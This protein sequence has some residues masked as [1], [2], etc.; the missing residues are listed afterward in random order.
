MAK[1]APDDV[2]AAADTVRLV[3]PRDGI[4]PVIDR[5]T[6]LR[7]AVDRYARSS[8]P[9][10]F[11]AE[12]ASGYRYSQRAYLIQLRRPDAGT[13][14]ID[15]TAVPDLTVVR[16]AFA[17]DEWVLHAAN[18]DLP[19]M[20]ELSLLPPRLFD[21]ELA[22]R[23]LG[24]PRVA[25]GTL[26]ETLLGYSLEKGHAAADWSTRPLP[27]DWLAYAALDV[28]L[29]I[30]LRNH[31]EAEL[32]EAGKLDWARE[33]FDAIRTAPTRPRRAEE[34]RRTSGIHKMTELRGLA[35]VRALWSAREE[36]AKQR[37]LAPGRVLADAA[38]VAV[39]QAKPTTLDELRKV[40]G[41]SSK[42]TSASTP[43]WLDAV[44]SALELP[45]ADLPRRRARS[46]EPP[47]T[48]RWGSKQ[49]EAAARLAAVRAVVTELAEQHNLPQENLA[50]PTAVRQLAWA[51]PARPTSDAVAALLR[52]EG[53]REW[54][55]SLLAT[56]LAG[57]LSS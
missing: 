33:E 41:V 43:R 21:T 32:A 13:L 18:Q 39:A 46:T 20:A 52:A 38:I 19:C 27:R 16:D 5:P 51:P 24:Y 7:A 11:D 53:V 26:V 40:P 29:L 8:G 42:R 1:V 35:I 48:K 31:L 25:L 9:V 28:E 3:E 36:L 14:L 47:A 56:N 55:I 23:L 17:D 15:P 4:P 6:D 44:T 34:W 12:R 50:P 22:G 37:D 45:D 30:E 10:A 57:A 2:A 49:P 54:Q